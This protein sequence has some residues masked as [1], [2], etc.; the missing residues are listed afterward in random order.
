[1]KPIRY[2]RHARRRM[3]EREVTEKEVVMTIT[4]PEYAEPSIRGRRNAYKFTGNRFIR[5]TYKEERGHILV[6]TVTVR[7]RPFKG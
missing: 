4:E 7:K 3:R 6:I 5:V 2:D 1:M